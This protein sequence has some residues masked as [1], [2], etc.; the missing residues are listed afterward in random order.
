MQNQTTY[1]LCSD[2]KWKTNICI[3]TIYTS[4]KF[5]LIRISYKGKKLLLERSWLIICNFNFDLKIFVALF[6]GAYI[7]F[8]GYFSN[9]FKLFISLFNPCTFYCCLNCCN[10]FL[11]FYACRNKLVIFFPTYLVS[12]VRT[13]GVVQE[14][15]DWV[16]HRVWEAFDFYFCDILSEEGISNWVIVVKEL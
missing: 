6:F 4:V 9:F 12:L 15:W 5:R 13:L 11:I 8:N 7:W 10:F 14:V 16:L 2:I 3:Y 1:Q